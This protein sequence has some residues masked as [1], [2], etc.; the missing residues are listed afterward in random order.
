MQQ[1]LQGRTRFINLLIWALICFP[2]A[3]SRNSSLMK[4]QTAQPGNSIDV[5]YQI[6]TRF[7]ELRAQH[8]H[9]L[10]SLGALC[11]I[12]AMWWKTNKNP[13]KA[14][15]FPLSELKLPRPGPGF[16]PRNGAGQRLRLPSIHQSFHAKTAEKKAEDTTVSSCPLF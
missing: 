10:I 7:P 5:M 9:I 16:I 13:I 15:T 3:R 8:W 11:F 14:A 4:G 2:S 12:S 6:Q 1:E